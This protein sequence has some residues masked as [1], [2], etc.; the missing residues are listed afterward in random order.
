M[1]RFIA[2]RNIEPYRK[3][4]ITEQDEATRHE[5]LRLLAEEEAKLAALGE[6][7]TRQRWET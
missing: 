4:L 7:P 6:Q 5:L 1:D 3:L 2:R